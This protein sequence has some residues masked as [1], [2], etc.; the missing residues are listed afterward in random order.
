MSAKEQVLV[1]LYYSTGWV[2]VADLVKWIEYSNASAFRSKVLM[3]LHKDRLIE[4]DSDRGS[5]RISPKGDEAACHTL[6][7]QP[8]R[9]HQ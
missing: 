9:A 4:F 3:P 1:L 5:A 7:G 2:S 6:Q 8:V